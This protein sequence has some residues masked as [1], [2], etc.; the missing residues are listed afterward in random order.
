MKHRAPYSDAIF[1]P[2]GCGDRWHCHRSD[3]VTRL[4]LSFVAEVST[5]PRLVLGGL[6]GGAAKDATRPLGLELVTPGACRPHVC[7]CGL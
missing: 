1:P 6:G 4:I 3:L 5:A 7:Y 2:T